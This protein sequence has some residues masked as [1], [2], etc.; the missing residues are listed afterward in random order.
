MHAAA[1]SKVHQDQDDADFG[2]GGPEAPSE[3]AHM[4]SVW[5]GGVSLATDIRGERSTD[6]ADWVP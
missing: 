6:M 3:G 4:A 1:Q 5:E 2:R